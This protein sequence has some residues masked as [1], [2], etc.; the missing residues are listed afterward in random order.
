MDK[1]NHTFLHTLI[2]NLSD[3]IFIV[4]SEWII[5]FV[6]PSVKSVLGYEVNEVL[7]NT[8]AQII[9]KNDEKLI[10]D[11]CDP[12]QNH[13]AEI[14]IARKDGTERYFK[15]TRKNLLSDPEIN[16]IVIVLHDISEMKKET[17]LTKA[18]LE[19]VE[20]SYNSTLDEFM[21]R[22]L[23]E[24][25]KL[26]GSNIGFYHFVNE[27]QESLTLQIWSTNTI[28][29]MC[30]AEGKGSHYNISQAGVWVDCFY[31]KK[32]IIH[33]DYASLQNKKGMPEGHALVVRE[34]TIPMIR[35]NKVVA[36]LGVGNKPTNYNDQ[37]IKFVTTLA[38]LAWDITERKRWEI[39]AAERNYSLIAKNKELELKNKDL[40][41][42]RNAT[43][44]IIDD[45]FAEIEER[46]T[47]EEAL[48][49]SEGRYLSILKT[50]M[51]GFWRVDLQGRIIEVN[52]SACRMSGYSAEELKKMEVFDLEAKED[53]ADTALH[54]QKV[55]ETGQDQFE[56]CHKRKDGTVF[57]VEINV[58]FNPSEGGYFVVFIHNI[59]D[60]KR[61]EALIFAQRDLARLISREISN[62]QLWK[63]S[64]EI[65]LK[66]TELDSGGIYLFDESYCNL[67]LIS[68]CGLSDKF[69]KI[70]TSYPSTSHNV[71]VLFEGKPI[72]FNSSEFKLQKHLQFEG[73]QSMASIPMKYRDKILGCIN[74]ASRTSFEISKF[75][76][77]ALETLTSEL[78]NIAAFLKNALS[79]RENVE[80]YRGLFDE[81]VAAIF[82]FDNKK[83][84]IDSNQAGLSLLG[85]S[86]N[87]LLT[88]SIHDVDADPVVVLNAHEEL[89]NGGRL[90]NYEHKLK[91]KDGRVIEVL[92]N[93]SPLSDNDG[94]VIGMLSTLINITKEKRIATALEESE[95]RYRN[96]FNNSPIPLWEEDFSEVKKHLENLNEEDKNDIA[97]YFSNNLHEILQCAELAKVLNV[98]DAVIKLFEAE[99]K[100]TMLGNLDSLFTEDSLEVFGRELISLWKKEPIFESEMIAQ[101]ITGKPIYCIL[102]VAISPDSL[103]DWSRVNVSVYD[104]TLRR[105]MEKE[106][107]ESEEKFRMLTETAND[108]IISVDASG[109]ITSWNSSAMKC[110]GYTSEEIIGQK[111]ELIIPQGHYV[112]HF[113]GFHEA[114]TNFKTSTKGKTLSVEGIRKS[115]TIFPIELSLSSWHSEESVYF[116]AIIRDI[117][118]RVATEKELS[119]YRDHLEELVKTRTAELNRA[120]E[121]LKL[122][123]EKEKEFEFALRKSLEK[124]KE[125]NDLKTRFIS[126][127]SHEFRTP[128]ASIQLSSGLL[129]RY[130]TKWSQERLNDHFNRI[131]KSIEN[132]TNLLDGVLTIS[133]AD[134]DKILFA[135]KYVDVKKLCETVID[136]ISPYVKPL[137]QLK[138]IYKCKQAAFYLDQNLLH[139]ILSN[140][141]INALKYS[142]DGGMVRLSLTEAKNKLH[143]KVEDS[144][145]GIP[146]NEIPFLFEP[147]Y[148]CSNIS[149]IP[150]SGL[151][152]SI[153][154][155]TVSMH[156]GKIKVKSIETKGTAFEVT[157]PIKVKGEE[158][159]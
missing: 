144:G 86:K 102:K 1:I 14:K 77:S 125:L 130:A 151:G 91:R 104:I 39:T 31:N 51:D 148:R 89:L 6:S 20:F 123:I 112:K 50:A 122:E 46:K 127:A 53:A 21:Q 97:K 114:V 49:E 52:E 55:M 136:E 48:R 94:N 4:D 129:Q 113:S 28:K 106:L 116:T 70:T 87:E 59:T 132:L 84:F 65:V 149:D 18:R 153:V 79:L 96:L 88:M 99:D 83:N 81:S 61:A 152:L 66:A 108:A 147:F 107:G 142:P 98:N 17:L 85:Y 134:S 92:N 80:K 62:E 78:G 8:W 131:N 23:D 82:I 111:V 38:D 124:E 54:I 140:L 100:S 36:I 57:N 11:I 19:L 22:F 75:A 29:T 32:P 105:A 44:N 109:N 150:G 138:F 7:E 69:I 101:T 41:N 56:S 73:L 2:E 3:L 43:L 115:G 90:I 121:T 139:Y 95:E 35:N 40:Q 71:Q 64:L 159:E 145:I 137:H 34:L 10:E 47:K 30:N 72:Y 158:D 118:E 5:K 146:E 25:E 93:S 26:T 58:K 141:L 156:N 15:E 16:G 143:I 74:V 68:H 126:T 154:E 27:D 24:A 119:A 110:F 33:N 120:N 42:V 155:K 103:H 9:Y 45:L 133:R 12:E 13:S 157:L 60:R 67:N 37:D 135:P 63:E 76:T 128:L 117:S